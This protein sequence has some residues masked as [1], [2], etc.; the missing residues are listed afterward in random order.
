MDPAFF[1]STHAARAH[2]SAAAGM[3]TCMNEPAS[4][5]RDACMLLLLLLA[6]TAAAGGCCYWL[7]HSSSQQQQQQSAASSSKK[8]QHQQPAVAP[9][10]TARFLMR[11]I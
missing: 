8:Q 5:N 1:Y 2:A 9:S 10:A 11:G 3:H 7:M 6:A 4:M